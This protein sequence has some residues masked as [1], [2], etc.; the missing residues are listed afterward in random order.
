ML[1]VEGGSEVVVMVSG[2]GAPEQ[3]FVGLKVL[4]GLG[5]PALKSVEL[6]SVSVQPLEPRKSAV[7]LESPGAAAV[8]EQLTPE[9]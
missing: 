5:E 2:A 9:P 1:T 4:R 3:E 6:L 8:S 7:V